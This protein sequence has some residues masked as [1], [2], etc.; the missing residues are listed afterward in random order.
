MRP[1]SGS[2]PSSARS[3]RSTTSPTPV[4]DPDGGTSLGRA[5]VPRRGLEPRHIEGVERFF[6]NLEKRTG[7]HFIHGQP[8]GLGIV[9]GSVLHDS[10]ADDMVGA[11]ARAGVD[12]R[13][14]AMGVSWED[15]EAAMRTLGA[16]VR[17]AGLWHRS[18]GRASGRCRRRGR[19]P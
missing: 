6:Y 1:A 4:S 19:G 17:E 10:G 2:M 8:V 3:T 9:L 18:R 5:D 11:L 12:V 14:E 7:R 15:A 16:F 13:P